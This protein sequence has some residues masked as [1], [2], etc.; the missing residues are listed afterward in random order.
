M[1]VISGIIDR[2]KRFEGHLFRI[3]S[4]KGHFKP[5]RAGRIPKN[6]KAFIFKPELSFSTEKSQ[7]GY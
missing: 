7:K 1:K 3:G 4:F 5:F 6:F 2:Q